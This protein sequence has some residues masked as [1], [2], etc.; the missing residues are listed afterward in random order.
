M[1]D[2]PVRSEILRIFWVAFNAAENGA[3]VEFAAN[4]NTLTATLHSDSGGPYPVP[5][6]YYL[7]S[8][9]FSP[10]AVG[11][12]VWISNLD[13]SE[14][15]DLDRFWGDPS[16]YS[17]WKDKD[18]LYRDPRTGSWRDIHCLY[19]SIEVS[20][21]HSSDLTLY[22][23]FPEAPTEFLDR[24]IADMQTEQE[25]D[26]NW[27]SFL[28]HVLWG[29]A[30]FDGH[31]GVLDERFYDYLLREQIVIS[32]DDAPFEGTVWDFLPL[33]RYEENWRKERLEQ[34]QQQWA[35]SDDI[36]F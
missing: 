27:E 17:F 20:I 36:P 18:I 14:I 28:N 26:E 11:F 31:W 22:D 30:D 35:N 15:W 5:T 23:V 8:S 9:T 7:F 2:F 3:K 10:E 12:G 24:L 21:D 29:I 25:G 16:Y 32:L 4:G 19:D 13:Q 1:S 33:L 34:A 6:M